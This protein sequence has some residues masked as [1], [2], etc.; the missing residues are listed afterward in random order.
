[1]DGPE[2]D[3]F[4]RLDA[5]INERLTR[6]YASIAP[7]KPNYQPDPSDWASYQEEM[8]VARRKKLKH[9]AIAFI[10]AL[11]AA[12]RSRC[13][14]DR[15]CRLRVVYRFRLARFPTR[16]CGRPSRSRLPKGR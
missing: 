13:V 1:A 10:L 8:K 16:A 7:K 9:F 11:L 14:M 12:L 5:A 2:P 15:C 6:I 3:V 4:T